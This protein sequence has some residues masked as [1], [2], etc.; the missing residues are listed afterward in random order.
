MRLLWAKAGSE[1]LEKFSKELTGVS[2]AAVM[3]LTAAAKGSGV[4]DQLRSMA[5]D[6]GHWQP[7]LGEE[8]HW[9]RGH[10]DYN[11]IINE[12]VQQEIERC[13][14][15]KVPCVRLVG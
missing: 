5:Q 12:I 6:I 9:R 14:R 4:R 3:R 13:G 10:P 15:G 1:Q 7:A 2:V 11:R 8:S